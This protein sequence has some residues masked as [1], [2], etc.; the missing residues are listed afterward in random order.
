MDI[1]NTKVAVPDL[2]QTQYIAPSAVIIGDVTIGKH[3]SVWPM[4]VIRGDVNSITIGERTNVQDGSILHVTH[5][6]P[7]TSPGYPLTIGNDVTIG[8]GAILHGCT[9]SNFCL[10]GI[11][12]TVLD[13]AVIDE[14]VFL[15]AGSLVP[16]HKHL[17][18]GFLYQGIP[19]RPVRRLSEQEK[20]ALA[21]SASHYVKLARSYKENSG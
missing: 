5:D 6:G 13:G 10:I 20:Q 8:H 17:D 21:Y 12:S 2:E 9:V 3:S 15:A 16:P 7:Y 18:S 1:E 14:H 19:A 4:A 11:H